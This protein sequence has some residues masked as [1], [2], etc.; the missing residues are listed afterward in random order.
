M[1]EVPT[2]LSKDRSKRITCSKC[3]TFIA[4]MVLGSDDEGWLMMG[5]A[6]VYNAH[7]HCSNCG[8]PWHWAPC[9]KPSRYGC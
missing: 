6:L 8:Q 1:N 5:A 2:L 9:K 3:K 4:E 7:G